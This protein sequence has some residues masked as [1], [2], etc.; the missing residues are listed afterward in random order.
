MAI[1]IQLIGPQERLVRGM[2]GVSLI[3][4]DERCGRVLIFMDI[5]GA[6]VDWRGGIVNKNAI[7]TRQHRCPRQH[8][9]IGGR[10]RNVQRIVR[11]QWNEDRAGVALRYEIEAVIEELA[12]EGHPGIERSRDAEVRRH[13]RDVVDLL[14]VSGAEKPIEAGTRNKA[15]RALD[16]GRV[17]CRPAVV[18]SR[19]DRGR[20]VGGLVDDQV[21]DDARIGV[22]H[23]TA[24][25][26]IGR[27]SGAARRSGAEETGGLHVGGLEYRGQQPGERRIGRTEVGLI[28]A[29]RVQQVVFAAVDGAQAIG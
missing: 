25:L 10:A 5:V 4:I 9:E 8:H 29:A 21:G 26:R 19:G 28:E 2:R 16:K 3:L 27:R 22:E 20:I 6:L 14:V 7:R 13:V 24:G 1:G 12:E 15:A 17:P 23:A 18:R 11:L